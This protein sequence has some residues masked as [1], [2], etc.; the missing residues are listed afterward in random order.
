MGALSTAFLVFGIALLFAS[1][2]ATNFSLLASSA[3]S[4]AHDKL[5]WLGLVVMLVGLAFKIAAFPMQMWAPD[6]YQGAPTPVTAFLAVASK[7]AGFVILLRV[8]FVAVPYVARQWETLFIIVAGI[9]IL[10]GNLCAIPQRNLKRLLGYSSIAQAG[11]LLLGIAALNRDGAQA[12][13][14]YL[15]GYL[16]TLGAVFVVIGLVCRESEDVGA[17]AG[18]NQRSPVLAAAL[19]MGMISLGGIPPLAGFAGKFL[20]IKAVVEHA[21]FDPRYYY[22]ALVMVA[23]VVI[24]LYY[25]FGVVR[26]IYWPATPGENNAPIHISPPMKISLAVCMAGMVYLGLFP[27]AVLT[28]TADA[29][30]ALK[31]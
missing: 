13:V 10:Y 9:T 1:S 17:L 27:N 24:S 15:L 23:G 19:A 12:V 16:F 11:Y 6:V 8:L 2:S 20:L 28:A 25:Y 22:L 3:G 4:L 7:A 21:A 29:V 18:L 14:Y 5:F 31:F 26:A 30:K